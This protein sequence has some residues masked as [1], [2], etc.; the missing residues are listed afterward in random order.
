MPFAAVEPNEGEFA[1]SDEEVE[2]IH[3]TDCGSKERLA[4]A[5]HED[6]GRLLRGASCSS[7]ARPPASRRY[8]RLARTTCSAS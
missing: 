5:A 4:K 2:T 7:S 6:D 8:S 3:I 1:R